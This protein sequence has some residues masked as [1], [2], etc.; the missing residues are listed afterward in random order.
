[1]LRTL[2]GFPLYD[3]LA[4]DRMQKTEGAADLGFFHHLTEK[5]R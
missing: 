3:R 5:K 2:T 4:S 1:M